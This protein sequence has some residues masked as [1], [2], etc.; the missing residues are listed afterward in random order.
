MIYRI[1]AF[2][3]GTLWTARLVRL[4]FPELP[5]DLDMLFGQLALATLGGFTVLVIRMLCEG[6]Q[7]STR[8]HECL[9][10]ALAIGALPLQTSVAGMFW[11]LPLYAL[12]AAI[13][14]FTATLFE[15]R[16]SNKASRL[17]S[18]PKF[19]TLIKYRSA[20]L[21]FAAFVI[22]VLTFFAPVITEGKTIS[23]LGF[24][25]VWA[26][27]NAYHKSADVPY[28]AIATDFADSMY[29]GYYMIYNAVRA[30]E[31]FPVSDRYALGPENNVTLLASNVFSI[32]FLMTL[33]F[34]P[35][36]GM[37][38]AILL[39]FILGGFATIGFLRLFGISWL[40]ALFGA[41]TLCFSGL[42]VVNIWLPYIW[43]MPVLFYCSELLLRRKTIAAS[44]FLTL[45]YYVALTTGQI[46]WSVHLILLQSLY[47]AGRI[48]FTRKSSWRDKFQ[49]TA[50]FAFAG[51]LA[52]GLCAFMILPSIEHRKFL[53]LEYRASAANAFVDHLLAIM[54]LFPRIAGDVTAPF[55]WGGNAVERA[56]Y[57]G[58]I[59][60]VLTPIALLSHRSRVKYFI[61][62]MALLIY[63]IITNSFGILSLIG[64]L[65]IFDSSPSTRLR[66]LWTILGA[67]AAAFGLDYLARYHSNRA[68][69][70][71]TLVLVCAPIFGI[72]ALSFYSEKP[73]YLDF[74]NQEIVAHLWQQSIFLI[75]GAAFLIILTHT[76]RKNVTMACMIGLSFSEL[77]SNFSEYPKYI[78]AALAFPRMEAT[79]YLQK[80]SKSD[81]RFIP[82]ERSFISFF[83]MPYNLSSI[84]PRGF[85]TDRQKALYQLIDPEALTVHPTMYFFS[86]HQTAYDS[87]LFDLLNVRHL[88]MIKNLAPPAAIAAIDRKWKLV[89][90]K[91]L[92]I[93]ENR[94][95]PRPAVLVSNAIVAGSLEN[96][97]TAMR[98]ED[99]SKVAILQDTSKLWEEEILPQEVSL[100]SKLESF[101]N[102]YYRYRTASNVNGYLVLSK[103]YHPAWHATLDGRPAELFGADLALMAL[104]V[105]KGR[106][107]VEL[108]FRPA[109][110]HLGL[111]LSGLSLM[112][113]ATTALV[114]YLRKRR[115]AIV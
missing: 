4:L 93:Y 10:I 39:R 75:V 2:I 77:H 59:P 41:V 62:G 89:F 21:T 1:V 37:T 115:V 108:K 51:I 42:S 82:I 81:S 19:R 27:F 107:I 34:G 70:V 53:T 92:E 43:A 5:G 23:P 9:L 44:L 65:P 112:L 84:Q 22:F 38:I 57:F 101:S 26:P 11:A 74:E 109:G 7:R 86:R 83:A 64:Q 32:D 50:L 100:R 97:I 3:A 17:E 69:K 24:T 71:L 30:G 78:D 90:D 13:I 110:L 18:A 114:I 79:D 111:W 104:Q 67:S 88:V 96:E 45:G 58:V 56:C 95:R 80:H 102:D 40:A 55:I 20:A 8:L 33:L 72:Y 49:L 54:F 91:E 36:W 29:P 105:P 25:Y 52:L 46:I 61:V 12:G 28:N 6:W 85:Y 16:K 48:I 63:V 87:A 73:Y 35:P 94:D 103:F 47:C 68:R 113:V 60:L 99:L 98:S 14:F 66:F 15:I 106:H 31:G 76:S